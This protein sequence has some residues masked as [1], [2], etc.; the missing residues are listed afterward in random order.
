MRLGGPEE[1]A[2]RNLSA[3]YQAAA[4]E[5]WDSAVHTDPETLP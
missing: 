3:G 5:S 1:Y 2:T 4:L